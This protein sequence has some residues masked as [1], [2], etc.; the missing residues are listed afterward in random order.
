MAFENYPETEKTTTVSST[1]PA[2]SNVN[3]K[4]I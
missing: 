3:W 4:A 1:T 2:K